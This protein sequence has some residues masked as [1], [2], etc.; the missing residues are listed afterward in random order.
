VVDPNASWL[1]TCG[2]TTRTLYRGEIPKRRARR[3]PQPLGEVMALPLEDAA[4]MDRRLEAMHEDLAP[5]GEMARYMVRRLTV[6]TVRLDRSEGRETVALAEKVR[7]AEADFDEK[8]NG[9]ADHL[10]GWIHAE[11][12]SY[13]RK[14]MATPEGVDRLVKVLLGLREDLDKGDMTPWNYFHGDKLEAYLG[15]RMSDIPESRGFILS[16][17]IQGKFEKLDPAEVAHLATPSAKRN[18]AIEQVR[19]YIDAEVARLRAHRETLDHEAIALSRAEAKRRAT[20]DPSSEA[21]LAR[22]YEANTERAMFRT[23][24]EIRRLNAE[25]EARGVEVSPSLGSFR[26]EELEPE[27]DVEPEVAIE[28]DRSGPRLP[29]AIGFVPPGAFSEPAGTGSGVR[30]GRSSTGCSTDSG[31]HNPR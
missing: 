27:L 17:A 25:A 6:L 15:R 12:I 20:F 19:E 7:H 16:E 14:L 30:A 29:V 18:W 31:G 26:A 21:I 23:L 22:R 9:D 28:R 8:R 5:R 13:R 1:E 2:S 11:P 10:L 3:K 24:G 4:E